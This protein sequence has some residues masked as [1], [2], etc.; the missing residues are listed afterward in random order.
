MPSTQFP[1][2]NPFLSHAST[3]PV[4]LENSPLGREAD[5]SRATEGDT[6]LAGDS[7]PF[8]DPAVIA[9]DDAAS[10]VMASPHVSTTELPKLP[11]KITKLQAVLHPGCK[12]C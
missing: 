12:L 4:L 3:M 6:L 8:I 9:D 2:H 1:K 7:N 5:P 11:A 10:S